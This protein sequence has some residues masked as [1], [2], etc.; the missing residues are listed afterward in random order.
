MDINFT[1]MQSCGNDYIYFNCFDPHTIITDPVALA[2]QLSPRRFNIGGDGIVLMQP[3]EKAD[4]RMRIFNRDGS[5][6]KMCGNAIRCVAKFLYENKITDKKN[7]T[8]DTLSGVKKLAL[9][10]EQGLVLSVRVDMGPAVFN[11]QKVPV[12]L[13]GDS[14]INRRILIGSDT[15]EITCISMGNPHAVVFHNDVD[16]LNLSEIG[17]DFANNPLFPDSVNTEFV[18]FIHESHLKMRVWERG[19]GETLACGTGA[20]ASAV[21]AVLNGYCKKNTDITVQMPGGDLVIQYTDETVFMTGDCKITFR[22]VV[23]V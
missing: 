1:K 3:T 20:C 21:A 11:P 2:V 8:I 17:P 9:N 10:I 6:G 12:N 14:V 4:A 19:S 16:A 7:I 23:T 5:E 13:V 22:G 18:Q 15:Y